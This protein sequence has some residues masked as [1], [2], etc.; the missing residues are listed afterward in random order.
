MAEMWGRPEEG[1]VLGSTL[2]A[3]RGICLLGPCIQTS[4]VLC[5]ENKVSHGH[6]GEGHVL[7]PTEARIRLTSRSFRLTI[8][9]D[10]GRPAMESNDMA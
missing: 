10:E 2:R 6:N 8:Q 5:K 7:T 9:V 4:L 3:S 1:I